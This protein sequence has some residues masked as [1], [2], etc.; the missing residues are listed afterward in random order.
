MAYVTTK[1]QNVTHGSTPKIMLRS[2]DIFGRAGATVGD[3][4]GDMCD[5]RRDN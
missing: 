5:G 3:D 2:Q 1:M 4:T